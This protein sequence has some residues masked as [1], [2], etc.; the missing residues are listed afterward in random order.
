MGLSRSPQG[1]CGLKYVA[2]MWLRHADGRS[3]QGECGLKL[4]T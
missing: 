2:V 4:D 1:E 3:L